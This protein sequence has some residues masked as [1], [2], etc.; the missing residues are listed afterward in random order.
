MRFH[1]ETGS[2][3]QFLTED[4]L[5]GA[6]SL[7]T[8]LRSTDDITM[9]T[10]HKFEKSLYFHVSKNCIYQIWKI[11]GCKELTHFCVIWYALIT[12]SSLVHI[13]LEKWYNSKSAWIVFFELRQAKTYEE[14]PHCKLIRQTLLMPFLYF[15]ITEKM[16]KLYVRKELT[17]FC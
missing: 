1:V 16:F 7:K 4:T 10:L 9:I 6:D 14:P 12:L 2:T 11:V 13:T 3:H 17:K 8:T 15:L 5:L